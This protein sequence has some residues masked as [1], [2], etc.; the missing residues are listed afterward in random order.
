MRVRA[1]SGKD[2]RR[3]NSAI[4][5]TIHGREFALFRSGGRFFAAENNC[6]HQHFNT[7][8]QG[9]IDACEVECP[10]HGWTFDLRTGLPRQGNGRLRMYPITVVG[11]DLFIELDE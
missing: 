8:H 6:P 1:A 2:L 5:V 7:L 3:E 11:D 9:H 4:S 10:M